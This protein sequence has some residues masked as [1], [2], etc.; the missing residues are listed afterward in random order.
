MQVNSIAKTNKEKKVASK[1]KKAA[2][3]RKKV[4]NRKGLSL[5]MKSSLMSAIKQRHR[6]D[7][8]L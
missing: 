1:K 3:S 2:T 7:N 8:V 6:G 4:A 5:A